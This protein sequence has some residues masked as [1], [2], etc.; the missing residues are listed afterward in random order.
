MEED[1]EELVP[2][3][4]GSPQ[5]AELLRAA[6]EGSGLEVTTESSGI[7]GAYPVNVGDLGQ[8]RVLVRSRDRETA[9]AI[10]DAGDETMLDHDPDA[11]ARP[12]GARYALIAIAILLLVLLILAIVEGNSVT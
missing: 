8:T 6:L 9:R 2:V 7:G 4:A 11:S 12:E 5:D 1:H 10:I 3:F